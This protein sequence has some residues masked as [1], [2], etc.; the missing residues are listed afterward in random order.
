MPRESVLVG[1]EKELDRLRE[2]VEQVVSGTGQAVLVEGEPGIGKSSVVKAAA[3]LGARRGCQ[4]F[5]A[6][7]DELGRDLPLR[8]LI[9]ALCVPELADEHR[10]ATIG[11]LLRGEHASG[12]A[13]AV[14]ASEQMLTLVTEL[15]DVAP[16]ILIVDDLQW[17]DTDTIGVWRWLARSTGRT[18]LLLV[19]IARPVPNRDGLTAIRRA[20]DTIQLAGLSEAAVTELVA[21]LSAGEPG[22]DL[23]RLAAGAAG[24]PL[25]LTELMAS[26]SRADR[27][28]FEAGIVEIVDGPVPDSLRDAIMDRLDFVPPDVRAILRA[29]ALLGGEFFVAD[30]AVVL[31][32]RVMDLV[33]A[34]DVACA[35]GILKAVGEKLAFRHPLI[36]TALYEDIPEVLRTALH[37]EAA[38][39]LATAGAPVERVGPQMF[40]SV[41]TPGAGPM[42]EA[43]LDWLV[44]AAPTFVAQV[45]DLAVELLREA[46]RHAPARTPRGAVLGARLADALFRAGNG[47]EAERAARRVLAVARDP[48]LVVD[49]YST[50]AQCRAL[51]GRAEESI[52][53]LNAALASPEMTD[54]QRA[55]LLVALARAHRNVGEVSVAGAVAGRA[56]AIAETVDDSWAIGWSLHILIVVA[57]MRGDARS[58][59]PLFERALGV[60]DGDAT[61]VDLSLLLQINMVVALG[62]LDRREE[63]LATARL[64]RDRADDSGILVRL[65]QAQCA[66]GELLFKIGQWDDAQT[67]VEMLADDFKNPGVTCCDRGVS[68]VV[69]FRRGDLATARQ[70]LAVAVAAAS[71][72]GSR[73]VASLTLARSLDEEVEGRPAAALAVLAAAVTGDAEELDEV[74]ELLPEAARLAAVVGDR[75][76]AEVVAARAVEV[77]GRSEVPHR[78]GAAAF[79][80]GLRDGDA[81][82]LLVAADRYREAGR[83]LPRAEALEAAALLLVG[84]GDREG[85][86]AAF[87]GADELYDGLGAEWDLGRLRAALRRHGFRRGARVRRR[88]GRTGWESLTAAEVRV[89]ELVADGLS[90]RRIAERLFLS[91]RTIDT[92]VSR[93]LGKLAVRSRLDI[94][95]AADRRR[96]R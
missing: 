36:R 83:P 11:R 37:R 70:H 68:A 21:H 48:A 67:E 10:L 2:L 19:G 15:C 94:A 59:L 42:N 22:P 81:G 56:L 65:A 77:A 35:S 60:V 45:P 82:Q 47:D 84:G 72:L 64:V 39:A 4:V 25:Y 38:T 53:E 54:A 63:A 79:C 57:L 27:L 58:V 24:N 80:V 76:V 3:E 49:L 52:L 12:V 75:Q 55:R 17:A 41:R 71:H 7:A 33:Q 91:T 86:R 92:H 40:L 29:A 34:I 96:S 66:L 90:N 43:L 74:E 62:N 44:E 73:V 6:S 46:C 89:A 31:G 1:R 20:V 26:L 61:L 78:V 5:W 88:V 32:K 30:L 14:A 95:R 69:A 16:T 50:V 9:D 8:P 23:R 18:A 28:D 13:P 51:A 93:V 87:V 85:A